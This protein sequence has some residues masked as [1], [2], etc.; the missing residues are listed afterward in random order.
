MKPLDSFLLTVVRYGLLA[1]FALPF[2]VVLSYL[3]PW[4]SGKI[5]G[6]QLIIE[7]LFPL[8]VLL[9]FRRREFRPAKD[10]FL[11]ALLA[12]FAVATLA[13]LLGEN[14]HR[15][16]WDKPD[17]ITGLFFQYHLLAFFLMAGAVWRR[18]MSTPIVASIIAA[19]ILSLHAI[20]QVANPSQGV[21]DRGSATFGNPSYLGQFLVPHLFL[22]GWLIYRHWKIGLRWLWLSSAALIMVGV[23]MTKSKGALVGVFV[24]AS[25][26]ALIATLR[27]SGRVRMF[28]RLGL[29]AIALAIA[30]FF[31]GHKIPP[32]NRWLYANRISLQY[33]QETTGSRKLLLENA[34]K[35]VKQHP[36]LGWG[37][38]NFEDGFYF[39][40]DPV[41]LRYSD[42]ETR[43]DRPHNLILEMLHNFG[44]IGFLAYA[45]VFV[46]GAR[47]A[48]RKDRP[49]PAVGAVLLV[50]AVSQVA[51]NLF[52]FETPMSYLALFFMLALVAAAHGG[53]AP[54][55]EEGPD[56]SSAAA[57]PLFLVAAFVS[58]WCVRYAIVGT[59]KA[60]RLTAQMIIALSQDV[61]AEDWKGMLAELRAVKTPYYERDLRA[62]ASHLGRSR[63]EYIDG[64]FKDI[65]IDMTE[66]EYRRL[67]TNR[68]DYVHAL[69]TTSGY[70]S[71]WPRTPEQQ[72][73]LEDA[74][75]VMAV[76]SPNRHEVEAMLAQIAWEKGDLDTAEAHILRLRELDAGNPI[77]DG[78]WARWQI[79]FRDPAAGVKHVA[80]HPEVRSNPEAWSMIE[81]ATLHAMNARRWKEL[82]AMQKASAELGVR[83]VQWD[84]T[85]AIAAWGLGDKARSDALIQ[86]AL[87][88]YPERAELIRQIAGSRDQIVANG[89]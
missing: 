38:E 26:A 75:E 50:A 89:G 2:V 88:L 19:S 34:V 84:L 48:L 5:W 86:E 22:S 60:A 27:G 33:I 82:D 55:R 40:Y 14:R 42:Y 31:I 32:V 11:Y 62:L 1:V 85:G 44:I 77:G 54:E 18:A 9:A 69:V 8:Y 59:M 36:L 20:S 63:G 47:L 17:R 7:I 13:M 87:A 37:P 78:W 25:L 35:G 58:I 53:R 10:P 74:A 4:V 83:N 73:A 51:T 6:F 61:K 57:L 79:E 49:D 12:Y 46:F 30:G 15:S 81:Y 71:F 43:Q 56:E 23:F 68:S 70:L 52:I 41:T 80:E 39:N 72:A 45:A 3:Y 28:G 76:R 21:D 29:A 66:D 67:A 65:L 16:F 24:G 64:P